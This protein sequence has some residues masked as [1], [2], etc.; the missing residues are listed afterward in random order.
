M[1]AWAAVGFVL[2]GAAISWMLLWFVDRRKPVRIT[3]IRESGDHCITITAEGRDAEDCA[4][5]LK[6]AEDGMRK[7][8]SVSH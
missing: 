4:A 5:A 6:I 8:A 3:I 1:S 7:Y 2:F